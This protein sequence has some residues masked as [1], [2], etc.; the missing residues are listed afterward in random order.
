MISSC[1]SSVNFLWHSLS[2]S[3]E[4]FPLILFLCYRAGTRSL[5]QQYSYRFQYEV[6]VLVV[7][8]TRDAR[9][10]FMC[11]ANSRIKSQCFNSYYVPGT[12]TRVVAGFFPSRGEIRERKVRG[13][14][15][16]LIKG[17]TNLRRAFFTVYRSF[18]YRIVRT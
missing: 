10:R 8:P 11:S 5:L 1:C 16:T 3:N 9:L 18:P 2:A 7:V 15:S 13:R 12:S 14:N 17:A 4:C 6:E